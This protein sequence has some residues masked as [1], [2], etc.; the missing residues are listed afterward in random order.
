MQS[1]LRNTIQKC[2][3]RPEGRANNA[4]TIHASQIAGTEARV[5][6]CEETR[7]WRGFTVTMYRWMLSTATEYADRPTERRLQN[8][9]NVIIN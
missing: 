5:V 9:M 1:P 7:T 2:P 6:Y 8:A 3:D 4:A